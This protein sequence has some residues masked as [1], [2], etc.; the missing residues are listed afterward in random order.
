M[1]DKNILNGGFIGLV[2]LLIGVS[3]IVFIMFRKNIFFGQ[4]YSPEKENG[5]ENTTG[6]NMIDRGNDYIGEAREA[7]EML[8][9]N[10]RKTMG[11]E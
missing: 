3:I 1:R 2:M 6:E 5:I 4:T 11:E 7:K 10:S 8:E 9:R